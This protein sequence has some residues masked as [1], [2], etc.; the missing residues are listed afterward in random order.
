MEQGETIVI[1]LLRKYTVSTIVLTVLIAAFLI[2]NNSRGFDDTVMA[3]IPEYDDSEVESILAGEDIQ[4]MLEPSFFEYYEEHS[5]AG[6]EDTEGFELSIPSM[7]YSAISNQD[8]EIK[9]ELGE[10]AEEVVA[11]LD[12]EGW[13]EYTFEVPEDGYYQ[14]GMSYYTLKG[15]RSSLVRSLKI[16]G[17]YPF[18]QAKKLTFQRM[19]EEDSEP[20]LDNQGNEFN[21]S[22]TEVFG[23]QYKELYDSEAKVSEPL[24]FYLTAGEH[25]VRIEAVREPAAIGE[26]R[27]FSPLDHPVYEEVLHSYQEKGYDEVEDIKIKIQAEEASLRSDPTLRRIEDREPITEPFNPDVI[28]LNAFGGPGWRSGEQWAE[29]EFEVPESGLYNIGMRYGQWFLNGVP[30]QRKITIDG[31]LPFKEMNEVLY[32]YE[33]NFQMK[34]LGAEVR[35]TYFIWKK[36]STRFE[37]RSK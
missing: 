6:V 31:E 32:P 13:V 12:Q 19:W 14:M 27:I 36:A 28:T 34:Q 22:R 10:R 8:T 37:W 5:K 17:E 16:N 23:W 9:T 24:R 18:F 1:R 7:D 11:L 15:K 2:W 29:W 3:N 33:P 26:L 35:I 4:S 21:P 20:W 30:T 25:T